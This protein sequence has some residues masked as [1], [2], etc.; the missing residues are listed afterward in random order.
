MGK[1]RPTKLLMIL[2]AAAVLST[3]TFA[4]KQSTG[5]KEAVLGHAES[6]PR[7][8]RAVPPWLAWQVFHESLD[9]FVET[10]DATRL[11][12]ILTRQFA[13][14]PGAAAT[15]RATGSE[16]LAAIAE[17]DA[18]ANAQ[19]QARYTGGGPATPAPSVSGR[20][21][22]GRPLYLPKNTT[23]LALAQRDGL[24]QSVEAKKSAH[25]N[26]HLGRLRSSLGRQSILAI[27]RWVNNTVTK[28][29][30]FRTTATKVDSVPAISA[31]SGFVS[32]RRA[33]R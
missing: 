12:R 20:P 23:L 33:G 5:L 15:L 29:I 18:T 1:M 13:L 28:N 32:V 10:S 9:F 30:T 31:P 14:E 2:G 11:D 3:H 7:S 21:G 26:G 4:L 16:Y 25:L 6:L 8:P 27:E 19:I 22:A 17:E 24:F